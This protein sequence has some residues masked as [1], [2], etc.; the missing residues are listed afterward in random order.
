MVEETCSSMEVGEISL[1]Q[2]EE[3]G[4]NR[5][6]VEISPVEVANDNSMVVVET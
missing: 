3:I 5:V 2:V 1:D 6:V 4:S